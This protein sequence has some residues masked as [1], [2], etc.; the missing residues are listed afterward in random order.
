MCRLAAAWLLDLARSTRL[1]VRC[2]AVGCCLRCAVLF[3]SVQF[4][5]S[6]LLR[7][8]AFYLARLARPDD[9]L[10]RRRGRRAAGPPGDLSSGGVAYHRQHTVALSKV[11]HDCARGPEV[12]AV[13]NSPRACG[14]GLGGEARFG[15]VQSRAGVSRLPLATRRLGTTGP[16][17]RWRRP[18]PAWR[19][20]AS[21]RA[22]L[23]RRWRRSSTIAFMLAGARSRAGD[24]AADWRR[25]ITSLSA[26]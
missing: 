6:A 18:A 3:L 4:S 21:A 15:W 20:G 2:G 7:R 5:A 9:S 8:T 11:A 19:S 14:A 23:G 13:V 10:Q 12:T 22:G 25:A 1:G 24:A 16:A 17:R 26:A